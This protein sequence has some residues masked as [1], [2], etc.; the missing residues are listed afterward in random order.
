MPAQALPSAPACTGRDGGALYALF[1]PGLG[2]HVQLQ[3]VRC[4][5]PAFSLS[6][7]ASSLPAPS[8]RE[9]FRVPCNRSEQVAEWGQAAAIPGS[10]REGAV[11]RRRLREHAGAAVATSCTGSDGACFLQHP[12]HIQ[13][14]PLRGVTHKNIG[15]SVIPTPIAAHLPLLHSFFLYGFL[16]CAG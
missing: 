1:L 11:A 14:I 8:R 10:L 2:D 13:P 15:V 12:I 16:P 7:R 5:S 4:V 3:L 9:P 6:Q